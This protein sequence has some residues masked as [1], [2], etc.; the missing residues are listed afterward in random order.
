MQVKKL[1]KR[2]IIALL[3]MMFLPGMQGACAESILPPPAEIAGIALPSLGEALQRY[4][5]SETKNEDGSITEHYDFISEKEYDS[6]S[7]WLGIQGVK[8]KDYR[9]GRGVVTA[10]LEVDG[11]FFRFA[12]DNNNGEADITYPA[13]TYDKRSRDAEMR[14]VAAK[15]NL[16]EGRVDKVL[17]EIYRIPQY[18]HYPLLKELLQNDADLAAVVDAYEK[19]IAPFRKIGNNVV[20]GRYEQDLTKDGMEPIE[21]IV[22]DYNEKE[23]KALL[24]SKYALDVQPYKAPD[25]GT[26]ETSILRD[27]MNGAFFQTAFNAKEK[28]AILMTEVDNSKAQGSDEWTLEDENNTY[29]RVFAL[30]YMEAKRYLSP[31]SARTSASSYV[32]STDTFNDMLQSWCWSDFQYDQWP[33]TADGEKAVGWGLRTQGGKAKWQKL[34]V[35]AQGNLFPYE[36]GSGGTLPVRPALWLDLNA[37]FF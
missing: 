1:V 14:Y 37:D 26:W 32:L 27:W 16:R 10:D 3:T 21:W 23:N 17:A 19:R 9:M 33:K 20:F 5:D 25:A 18:Q 28:L 31:A 7:T 34:F 11:V 22:L 13:G 15:Q 35:D 30:S 36:G 4:P 8:L 2:I 6:F 12:Y 24:I 29:D